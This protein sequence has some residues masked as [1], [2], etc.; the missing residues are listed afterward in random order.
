MEQAEVNGPTDE[1]L[2]S[3]EEE[4]YLD[5]MDDVEFLAQ[6]EVKNKVYH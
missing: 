3:I 4:E 6:W 5:E 2:N 1:E